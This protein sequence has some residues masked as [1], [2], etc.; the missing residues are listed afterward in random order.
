MSLTHAGNTQKRGDRIEGAGMRLL[1]KPQDA[2]AAL[3][4]CPRLLWRF[5]KCGDIPCVRLGRA[6]RFDP[7]DLT[8]WIDRQKSSQSRAGG[9]GM[10]LTSGQSLALVDTETAAKAPAV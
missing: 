9:G 2:A 10:A 1:L 6:V 8:S 3:A 5:T 4:I 7:R